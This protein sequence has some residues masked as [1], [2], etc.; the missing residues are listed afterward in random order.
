MIVKT[1]VSDKNLLF[2]VK[3]K[4]NKVVDVFSIESE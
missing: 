4:A 3:D 1:D 2:S